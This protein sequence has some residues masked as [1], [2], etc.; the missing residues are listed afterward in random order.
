MGGCCFG[1]GFFGVVVGVDGGVGFGVVIG[2]SVVF[3]GGVSV[4]D[5]VLVLLLFL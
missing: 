2:G 5:F 4:L 1:F 3:D